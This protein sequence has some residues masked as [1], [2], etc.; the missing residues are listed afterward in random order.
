MK[1][2]AIITVSV[3]ALLT[4]GACSSQKSNTSNSS[5][6]EQSSKVTK[7][8][9]KMRTHLSLAVH[10]KVNLHNRVNKAQQLILKTFRLYNLNN[11]LQCMKEKIHLIIALK[12]F[13][14]LIMK[15]TVER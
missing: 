8:V 9:H 1:K 11:G 6:I 5:K 4:L 13:M 2:F 3:S 10:L 12:G 15:V 14:F 7:K